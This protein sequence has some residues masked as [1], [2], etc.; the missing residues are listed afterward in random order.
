MD[1][2]D[3]KIEELEKEIAKLKEENFLS[4]DDAVKL[5]EAITNLMKLSTEIFNAFH[6]LLDSFTR[7][8]EP[9]SNC[10]I[11]I[12]QH[13]MEY[14]K[15]AI[16][17]PDFVRI[18]AGKLVDGITSSTNLMSLAVDSVKNTVETYKPSLE[19]AREVALEIRKNDS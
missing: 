19:K 5:L 18:E 14:K 13:F 3:K 6:Q 8:S 16:F 9:A 12:H 17:D 4:T 7:L 15:G 11:S 10:T 2:K 1:E